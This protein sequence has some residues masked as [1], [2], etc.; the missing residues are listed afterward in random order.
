MPRRLIDS[1]YIFGIHEPGGEQQGGTDRQDPLLVRRVS[2][3]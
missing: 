3:E 1:P 2:L